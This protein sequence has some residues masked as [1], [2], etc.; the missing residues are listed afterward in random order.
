M[1]QYLRTGTERFQP[2]YLI[3]E[4]THLGKLM[5]KESSFIALLRKPSHFDHS[6]IAS[7][8]RR[9]EESLY[10]PL[11]ATGCMR[12]DIVTFLGQSSCL[13]EAVKYSYI[14]LGLG[15]PLIYDYFSTNNSL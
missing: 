9:F 11:S 14:I 15:A 10:A 13:L 1:H 2:F 6:F 8:Y 7:F 3:I 5:V 12:G 4:V